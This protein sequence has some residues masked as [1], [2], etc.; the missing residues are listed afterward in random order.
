MP[1]T[2][3]TFLRTSDEEGSYARR[4]LVASISRED[5]EAACAFANIEDFVNCVFDVMAT[6]DLDMA[7]GIYGEG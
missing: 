4:M 6:N 3:K 7:K 1:T 2:S 5:A